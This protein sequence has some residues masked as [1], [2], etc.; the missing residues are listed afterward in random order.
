MNIDAPPPPPHLT[1]L[2]LDLWVISDG[3]VSQA[4]SLRNLVF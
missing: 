2:P 1:H 4:I 3:G